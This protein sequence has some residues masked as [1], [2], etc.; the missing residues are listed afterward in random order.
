[1][2]REEKAGK[3]KKRKR[4]PK[5]AETIHKKIIVDLSS[6]NGCMVTSVKIYIRSVCVCMRE[7]PKQRLMA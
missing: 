5:K 6:R 4:Y 2:R 3:G 1:M 7:I